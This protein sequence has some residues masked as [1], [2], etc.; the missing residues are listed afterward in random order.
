MVI[1]YGKLV[2]ANR[3]EKMRKNWP[4]SPLNDEQRVATGWG[5]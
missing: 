2:G 3:D 5:W 1:F 4:F